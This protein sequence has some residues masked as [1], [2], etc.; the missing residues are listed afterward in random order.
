MKAEYTCIVCPVSCRVQVEEQ[1]DQLLISGYGCKR[2][3][4]HA[5]NEHTNPSRMLT[6]TVKI[7]SNDFAR[8]PVISSA[9]IPRSKMMD[10]L[11]LVY[12]TETI[13]PVVC[14]QVLISNI[15]NT[16]VDI[17]ASRTIMK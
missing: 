2:G 4:V 8:I 7:K 5:R 16:G 15:C 17:L 11:A 3:E 9:E 13:A 6:S 14:G 1:G 12:Q 10:C